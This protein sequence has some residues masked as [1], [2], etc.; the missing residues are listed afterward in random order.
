MSVYPAAG[1]TEGITIEGGG[2]SINRM[3]FEGAGT[4]SIATR[5]WGFQMTSN[6][7]LTPVPPVIGH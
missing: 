2:G 4:A 6:G 7:P 5:N 3:I 1:L